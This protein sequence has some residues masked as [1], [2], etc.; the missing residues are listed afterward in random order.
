MSVSDEGE[1]WMKDF[2][3]PENDCGALN[4]CLHQISGLVCCRHEGHEGILG[5]RASIVRIGEHEQY[6]LTVT[7]K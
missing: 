6:V 2:Q 3:E 5:D 1:D 7:P 4:K